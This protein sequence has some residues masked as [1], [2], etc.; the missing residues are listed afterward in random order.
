MAIGDHE[1][2]RYPI[3]AGQFE[4]DTQ[5]IADSLQSLYLE[6]GGGGTR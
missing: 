3:Q 2:D 4:S 5:K 1:W 6:G